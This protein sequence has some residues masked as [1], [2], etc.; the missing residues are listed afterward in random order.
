[1]ALIDGPIR[2]LRKRNHACGTGAQSVKL[3]VERKS[4]FTISEKLNYQNAPPPFKIPYQNRP[5]LSPSLSLWCANTLIY[6]FYVW[7]NSMII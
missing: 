1:M 3:A 4:R 5:S 7:N 6:K 2:H